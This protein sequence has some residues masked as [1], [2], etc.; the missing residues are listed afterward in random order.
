M[1]ADCY[2]AMPLSGRYDLFEKDYIQTHYMK[3]LYSIPAVLFI[4]SMHSLI[5]QPI[6]SNTSSTLFYSPAYISPNTGKPV[7]YLDDVNI[8]SSLMG[9]TDSLDVTGITFAFGKYG[10]QIPLWVDFYYSSVNPSATNLNN[11]CLFPPV[12]FDSL[13]AYGRGMFGNLF[14]TYGDSA[15][16]LFRVKTTKDVLKKKYNTFFVGMSF[17]INS[18]SVMGYVHGPL[19]TTNGTVQKANNAAT[20]Y[21]D[22]AKGGSIKKINGQPG[23]FYLVIWGKPAGSA[24]QPVPVPVVNEQPALKWNIYPN[25]VGSNTQIQMQLSESKKIR[26][27]VFSQTGLPELAVDKHVLPAGENSFSLNLAALPKGVHL[28]RLYVG[29]KLY[30]KIIYR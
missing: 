7:I 23:A 20:W 19:Y 1:L 14:K 3:K 6:Y 4:M 10:R 18:D 2:P 24:M 17:S 15:H 27:E 30:T 22:G 28:L 21:Y 8:P 12:H 26:V 25:P 9:A 29:D 16:T 5:A 13:F 11:I